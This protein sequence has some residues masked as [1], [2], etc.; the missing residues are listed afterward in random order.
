MVG[1]IILP[2]PN[3]SL[4]LSPAPIRLKVRVTPGTS[5][6]TSLELYNENHPDAQIVLEYAD[7]GGVQKK[8][9]DVESGALDFDLLD[10]PMYNV[11]AKEF[12]Y[13]LKAIRLSDEESNTVG[14]R[15]GYFLVSKGHEELRDKINKRLDELV[16]DGTLKELGEK[17]FYGDYT[18]YDLYK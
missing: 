16:A 15:Y 6:A 3:G 5:Y 11:Y 1:L 9:L 7:D 10:E 2:C 18:P 12:G 17:Y 14:S 13:K 8:L 4:S